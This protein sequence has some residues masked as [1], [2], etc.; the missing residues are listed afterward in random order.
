MDIDGISSQWKDGV[1]VRNWDGELGQMD[2][3]GL[4]ESIPNLIGDSVLTS[5]LAI[6]IYQT[7]D[8]EKT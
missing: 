8:P 5:T 2:F 3:D 4:R 6:T 1:L 7:W